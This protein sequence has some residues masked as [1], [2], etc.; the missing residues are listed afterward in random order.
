MRRSLSFRTAWRL[1]AAMEKAYGALRIQ[2]EPRMTRFLAAQLAKHHYFNIRGARED[3]GY[4]PQVSIEEG[5]RR[6]GAT[7]SPC[8]DNEQAIS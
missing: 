6:L 5:M 4:A 2:R 3:F 7:L 1:G 8:S